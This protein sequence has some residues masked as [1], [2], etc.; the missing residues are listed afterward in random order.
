MCVYMYV[1]M[2]VC[3]YMRVYVCIYVCVCMCVYVYMY[4]CVWVFVWVY[5]LRWKTHTFGDDAAGACV[6]MRSGTAISFCSSISSCSLSLT[7][8]SHTLF[9]GSNTDDWSV[10]SDI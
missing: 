10:F 4:V 7:G 2:F 8:P 3:V 9:S 6:I 5:I 1:Y